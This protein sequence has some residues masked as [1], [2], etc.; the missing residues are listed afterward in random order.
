MIDMMTESIPSRCKRSKLGSLYASILTDRTSDAD[1]TPPSATELARK[2]LDTY[3]TLASKQKMVFDD[4]PLKWWKQYCATLPELSL[5]VR[6]YLAIQ[7]TS[8]ASER[9]FSKAGFIVN[10]LRTSLKPENISMLTF[11]AT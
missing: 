10:K 1:V 6:S 9:L 2:Q 7:A 8:V 4:D 11:L 3:K 5:M